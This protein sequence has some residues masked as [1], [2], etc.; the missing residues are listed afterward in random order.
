MIMAFT[1]ER[2][3]ELT[4]GCALFFALVILVLF[5]HGVVDETEKNDHAKARKPKKADRKNLWKWIKSLTR[6]ADS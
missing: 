6:N 5:L 1:I 4:M 2:A 3:S